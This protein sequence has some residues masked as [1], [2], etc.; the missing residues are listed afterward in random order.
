MSRK[1]HSRITVRQA[2]LLCFIINFI[3]AQGYPPSITQMETAT[4]M[5]KS[6]ISKR[7]QALVDHGC[8]SKEKNSRRDVQL[9]PGNGVDDLVS[10]SYL[11]P[12]RKMILQA[13]E[14]LVHEN[15]EWPSVYAIANKSGLSYM[16]VSRNI[17]YLESHGHVRHDR[18]KRAVYLVNPDFERPEEEKNKEGQ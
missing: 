9:L 11:P 8:I 12:A 14:D 5:E 2:D 1:P 7:L 10:I 4:G 18:L 3:R 6:S 13:I 17:E 16:R 15:S